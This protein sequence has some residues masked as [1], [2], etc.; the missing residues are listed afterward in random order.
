MKALSKC[1]HHLPLNKVELQ[2]YPVSWCPLNKHHHRTVDLLNKQINVCLL[3]LTSKECKQC[4]MLLS[5]GFCL[6]VQL[7]THTNTV[8]NRLHMNPCTWFCKHWCTTVCKLY[9]NQFRIVNIKWWDVYANV[10]IKVMG[11]QITKYWLW[12][13]VGCVRS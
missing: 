13:S 1:P 6:W 8:C 7:W 10:I 2:V 11:S 4:E 3:W 9:E 5:F 12:T